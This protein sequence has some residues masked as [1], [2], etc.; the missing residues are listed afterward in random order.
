MCT[1]LWLENNVVK[2]LLIL[3]YLNKGAF[4]PNI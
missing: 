2:D 3:L 4:D 1:T